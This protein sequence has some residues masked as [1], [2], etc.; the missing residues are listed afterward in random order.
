MNPKVLQ[1]LAKLTA[2]EAYRARTLDEL[3]GIWRKIAGGIRNQYTIGYI[4]KNRSH[5]G[6]FR[7]VKVVAAGKDGKPL[8][9]RARKGYN[10]PSTN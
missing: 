8:R 3:P 10:A 5:D 7:S 1:D 4:S 6:T 9:V 2:G